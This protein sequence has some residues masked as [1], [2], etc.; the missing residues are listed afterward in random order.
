MNEKKLYIISDKE[1]NVQNHRVLVQ[2]VA[3]S[4]DISNGCNPTNGLPTAVETIVLVKKG[5]CIDIQCKLLDQPIGVWS[6]NRMIKNT[7]N[8]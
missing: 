7:I 8:I 1:A 4:V 6:Y 2:L 3:D 5:T